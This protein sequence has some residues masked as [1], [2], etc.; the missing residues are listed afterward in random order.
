MHC[1]SGAWAS[2]STTEP[3]PPLTAD[4]VRENVATQRGEPGALS[5]FYRRLIAPDRGAEP[6]ALSARGNV[7]NGYLQ[8][9]SLRDRDGEEVA[10]QIR[11]RS[12][13]SHEGA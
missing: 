1:D 8:V 4:S 13:R 9:F 12:M 11:T 2:F 3:G 10:D 7:L 6:V 5:R